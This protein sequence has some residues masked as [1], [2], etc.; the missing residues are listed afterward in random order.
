MRSPNP[1]KQFPE[2]E[3]QMVG[4]C[5]NPKKKSKEIQFQDIVRDSPKELEI[6]QLK[7]AAHSI[8]NG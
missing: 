4:V 2:A 7:K 1:K 6:K 5:P 3:V 8:Q